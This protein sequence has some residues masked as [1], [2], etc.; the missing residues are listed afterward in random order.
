MAKE[1][2][3]GRAREDIGGDG[4]FGQGS[5]KN[6]K[7]GHNDSDFGPAWGG[8]RDL[9]GHTT[10]LEQESNSRQLGGGEQFQMLQEEERYWLGLG[11]E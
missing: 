10:A 9:C 1:G 8:G 5:K 3:Y 6:P 2:K 4:D 7:S 11:E